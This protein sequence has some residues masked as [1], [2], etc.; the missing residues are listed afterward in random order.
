MSKHYKWFFVYIFL[1]MGIVLHSQPVT[2]DARIAQ[3]PVRE[4]HLRMGNPGPTGKAI[5]INSKYLTLGGKP[6][7]PVMG[8]MHYSRVPHDRWE[9]ELLKMKACGINIIA[10]YVFWIHHEEAEGEFDWNGDKD[11]RAFVQLCAKH[12]LWVYPRIGPWCHGEVRNGGLPDWIVFQKKFS[13]RTNDP[14]YLSY[15]NRWYDEIGKQ[16]AGLYYKDDGP[17]IGI[18]LENEYWRGK[19]GEEHILRL[20]QL[21]LAHGMDVP[22]YTVTGWRN[23]SVPEN[24]VIPL[25][26]GYPAAPWNTD[27]KKITSNESYVFSKPVNDQSIGNKEATD[28]YSPDYSNYPYLTCELGIGNEI[29][30]HRRPVIDPIDGM[31]IATASVASGSNLI[32]YYVFTGGLNPVGKYT[33]L[34]EDRLETGCWNEY[35]DI[36]YDFQAAISE[37]GE[38]APA[39]YKLKPLHYFLNE[40]GSLLAPMTPVVPAHNE[41]PDSLQYAFRVQGNQGFLF[42]SNYYRGY[43]KPVKKQMQFNIKLENEQV[44]LPSEPVDIPDSTIFIWPVNLKLGDVL[45]HYATAQLMACVENNEMNDW[46]F[47]ASD[48]IDPEFSIKGENIRAITIGNNLQRKDGKYFLLKDLKIGL[49]EPLVVETTSGQKQR[50]FILSQKQAEM[51]WLLKT[52]QKYFAFLSRANLYM[53]EKQ[54]LQAFSIH[55][56]DTII[57][58][59]SNVKPLDSRPVE[60]MQYHGFEKMVLHYQAEKKPGYRLVK[61]DLKDEAQWL[62]ISSDD[63]SWKK[64][65]YH[66]QFFKTV[67]LDNSAEIR[68]ATCYFIA[69][70]EATVR[71]NEH[72]L[73]QDM[74]KGRLTRLD[75]TGYLHNGE[76]TVL[77]DFLCSDGKKAFAA[78]IEVEYYNSDKQ[79]FVSDT[80]WLT[81]EQYKIPAPLETVRGMKNPECVEQP[82]SYRDISF[83]PYRYTLTV[84]TAGINKYSHAFLRINYTGDKAQCRLG[85]RLVADNFNNGTTWS[86]NLTDLLHHL[87]QP[88]DF[89]LKPLLRV[90]AIYFD[91]P[92]DSSYLGMAKIDNVKIDVERHRLFTVE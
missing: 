18:Q 86:L 80:T 85:G 89:E 81:T 77:L 28:R 13:V 47:V 56:D 64:K 66:R 20:K 48:A 60:Q 26:G 25:W 16:L 7:F 74:H 21:A 46:Y 27:L 55:S 90:D 36:S 58:L 92:P 33:T 10:T 6:I 59:N 44:Q 87:D 79:V 51:F 30:E 17:I 63:Y 14:M 72:W 1:L 57:A 2:I 75:L 38:I 4:G 91:F 35:P 49:D 24:E 42:V 50:I 68:K 12:G 73:N 43:K 11:L 37:T 54:Q 45:L 53:D 65:L 69:D 9:D 88:L 78:V 70:E 61:S 40:F 15:V 84:D 23:A 41:S 83:T 67:Q 32:G 82:G 5:V 39:Y 34:E 71:I 8:E 19:K 62:K 76:N 3:V 52:T 29:T 31:A 22:M